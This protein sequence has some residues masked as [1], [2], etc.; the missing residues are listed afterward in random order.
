MGRARHTKT[1]DL[2]IIDVM[3]VAISSTKNGGIHYVKRK[4]RRC[5]Q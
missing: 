1:I 5:A 3:L 4:D 2:K